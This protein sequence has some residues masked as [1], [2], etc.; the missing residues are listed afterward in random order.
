MNAKVITISEARYKELLEK[1]RFVDVIMDLDEC[2]ERRYNMTKLRLCPRCTSVID[3]VTNVCQ[4]CGGEPEWGEE[5]DKAE[6][7]E[8]FTVIDPDELEEFDY[9]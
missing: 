4:D 6:F 8:W 9:E 5:E 2:P 1:E 3:P 7:D